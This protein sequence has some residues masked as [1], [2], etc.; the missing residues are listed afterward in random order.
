MSFW[1][2]YGTRLI[3]LMAVMALMTVLF[4]GCGTS[5]K[6]ADDTTKAAAN[7]ET[8][9]T[10]TTESP[11]ESTDGTETTVSEAGKWVRVVVLHADGS[12][13]EFSYITET[14]YLG[15]LLLEK[16][17]IQIEGSE[18]DTI[19][20]TVNEE[21]A[22]PAENGAY[23]EFYIGDAYAPSASSVTQTIIEDGQVYTFSYTY[24]EQEQEV[25]DNPDVPDEVYE[26]EEE[27]YVV[28][29][30]TEET[31]ADIPDETYAEETP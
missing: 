30:M 23:W 25:D 27:E 3:A 26:T 11:E 24:V 5:D 8:E 14:L 21:I 29:D 28:E 19:V 6:E 4:V 20:T 2:K 22:V 13:V 10:E 17:L 9:P 16:N 7:K 12:E 1:K 15:D 31:V 18:E